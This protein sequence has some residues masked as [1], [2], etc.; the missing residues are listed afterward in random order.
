MKAQ[1]YWKVISAVLPFS[2]QKQKQSNKYF[3]IF[4]YKAMNS[5]LKD[6]ILKLYTN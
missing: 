1:Q 6:Y 5:M 3:G 4:M 2:L